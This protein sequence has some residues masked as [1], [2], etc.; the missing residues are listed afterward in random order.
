V[1]SARKEKIKLDQLLKVMF[2]LSKKVTVNLLNG[3]FDE[4]YNPKNVK[5]QYTNNEFVLE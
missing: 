2:K 3:L 4:N 5:V 1:V